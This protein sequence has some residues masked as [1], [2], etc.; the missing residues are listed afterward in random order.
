[1]AASLTVDAQLVRQC[2]DM[3][4]Q[5]ESGE[6]NCVDFENAVRYLGYDPTNSGVKEVL[7]NAKKREKD[8]LRFDE[9]AEL[10][11]NFDGGKK[12]DTED[13]LREAFK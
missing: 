12:E 1:M 10:L 4:V 7:K 3:F 5:R 8:T 9:F 2:F 11:K 6:M 13:S